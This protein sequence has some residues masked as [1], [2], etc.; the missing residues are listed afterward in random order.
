MPDLPEDLAALLRARADDAPVPPAP[1]DAVVRSVRRRQAF[2]AGGTAAAGLAGVALV[3]AVAAAV[4]S[5]SHPAGIEPAQPGPGTLPPSVA[6]PDDRYEFCTQP[7]TDTVAVT[8]S[9][10]ELKYDHGCY[11]VRAGVPATLTFTN[12]STLAHDVVVRPDGG[13]PFAKTDVVRRNGPYDEDTVDLGT[14][15]RGDYVLTCDVHPTMRAQLV[16]R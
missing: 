3:V 15:A 6:V 8:A 16:A 9:S 7:A 10:T 4:A 2:R 11:V 1:S 13:E 12:R 14:L 5:P